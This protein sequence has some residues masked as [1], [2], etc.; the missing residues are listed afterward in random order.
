MFLNPLLCSRQV[1]ENFPMPIPQGHDSSDLS[2]VPV[3]QYGAEAK[4]RRKKKWRRVIALLNVLVMLV[5]ILLFVVYAVDV[6]LQPV[7]GWVKDTPIESVA[8]K[9]ASILWGGGHA[10]SKQVDQRP[11]S[12]EEKLRAKAIE[13][14]MLNIQ[15][16]HAVLLSNGVY[17][18]GRLREVKKHYKTNGKHTFPKAWNSMR[19][20]LPTSSGPSQGFLQLRGVSSLAPRSAAA[21]RRIAS[22]MRVSRSWQVLR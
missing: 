15:P 20:T 6:D 19:K 17:Q 1:A 8:R 18:F 11:L 16:S 5:A 14:R 13:E 12:H 9:T 22:S 4:A 21:A 3:D 10:I 2:A 7:S